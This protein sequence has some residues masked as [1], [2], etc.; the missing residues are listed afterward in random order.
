MPAQPAQY[1]P[2]LK[3]FQYCKFITV[4]FAGNIVPALF[5]V[6]GAPQ[7]LRRSHTVPFGSLWRR[8]H[9]VA[10]KGQAT[11]KKTTKIILLIQ[12]FI[13]EAHPAEAHLPSSSS[14]DDSD[15]PHTNKSPE[16]RAVTQG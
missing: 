1:A 12:P 13:Q 11:T 3:H 4:L 9:R 2:C 14:N 8:W 5:T 6:P 15:Q 7:V 10:R 16:R